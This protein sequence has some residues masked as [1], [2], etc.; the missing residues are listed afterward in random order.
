MA[1]EFEGLL[2]MDSSSHVMAMGSAS[3]FDGFD[4]ASC[5]MMAY[6]PSYDAPAMMSNYGGAPEMMSAPAMMAP[7]MS[8]MK[9]PDLYQSEAVRCT[10]N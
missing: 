5:D 7:A 10:V 1:D 9:V 3:R 8:S 4:D 2:D 6:K